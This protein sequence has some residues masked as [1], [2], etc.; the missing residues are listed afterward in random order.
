MILRRS[1]SRLR[2][3]VA[4]IAVE[5]TFRRLADG[6]ANLFEHALRLA[7][8]R[9]RGHA[10]KIGGRRIVALHSA[11]IGV[12]PAKA[13]LGLGITEA[14]RFTVKLNSPCRLPFD[15]FAVLVGS[16]FFAQRHCL[17]RRAVRL[18]GNGVTTYASG[19]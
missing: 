4:S 12:H 7:M 18:I 9:L 8:P 16:C 10:E 5:E 15:A 13:V 6:F 2:D 1:A 3:D 19:Q 14:R 11:P 17:S